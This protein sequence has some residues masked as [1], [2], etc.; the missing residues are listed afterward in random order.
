MS[1]VLLMGVILLAVLALTLVVVYKYQNVN[2]G[3]TSDLNQEKQLGYVFLQTTP[4]SDL[5]LVILQLEDDSRP[6]YI[7]HKSQVNRFVDASKRLHH[8]PGVNPHNGAKIKK[9][10]RIIV[11]EPECNGPYWWTTPNLY[12]NADFENGAVIFDFGRFSTV[13]E[14]QKH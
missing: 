4:F 6:Q 2:H 3:I 14:P 1:K 13:W 5:R 12:K 9:L 8:D 10:V 7:L 11:A